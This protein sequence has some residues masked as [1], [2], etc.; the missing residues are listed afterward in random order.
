MI[1]YIYIHNSWVE[2]DF[3]KKWWSMIERFELQGYERLDSLVIDRNFWVP[4]YMRDMFFAGM[5]TT[6]RSGSINSSFDKYVGKKTS[7]KEFVEKYK[8]AM[9]DRKEKEV[10]A[11]FSTWHKA[12]VLKSPS[13]FEKQMSTIYTHEAFKKF[14]VEVLGVSACFGTKAKEDGV[15]KVYKVQDFEKSE[16]FIITLDASKQ[17][18]TCFC[19][20]LEFCGYICRHVMCLFQSLGIF[21]IP[22]HY[23]LKR[24][25]KNAKTLDMFGY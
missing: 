6:Q 23:V 22:P 10:H 21:T 2:E 1:V 16:I 13:P 15:I 8:I 17:E 14:Q 24:W 5:S 7:L 3:E 20:R 12:P 9:R 25:C 4:T 19:R 11:D 18:V